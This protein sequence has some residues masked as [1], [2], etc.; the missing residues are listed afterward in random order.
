MH[1]S[2]TCGS[3]IEVQQFLCGHIY[4]FCSSDKSLPPPFFR[5][6]LTTDALDLGSILPTAGWI[7]NFHPLKR[8]LTER[9]NKT[10]PHI[11]VKSSF[12]NL[13]ILVTGKDSPTDIEVIHIFGTV[14]THHQTP[15][16]FLFSWEIGNDHFEY[17]GST[18]S[19]DEVNILQL[20]IAA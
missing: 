1:G 20:I 3:N 6:R 11:S 17:T 13:M 7:R 8:A 9:T 10:G 15:I 5:S 19:L 16:G 2:V 12:L 4:D 14:F 18:G